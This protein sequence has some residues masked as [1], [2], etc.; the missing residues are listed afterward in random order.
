[1]DSSIAPEVEQIPELSNATATSAALVNLDETTAVDDSV[2]ALLGSCDARFG[3]YGVSP[4]GS[5]NIC[6]DASFLC[7]NILG[8]ANLRSKRLNF[9][10]TEGTLSAYPT[11]YR[12]AILLV[13]HGES[14]CAVEPQSGKFLQE[15]FENGS[16]KYLCIGKDD[17]SYSTLDHLKNRLCARVGYRKPQKIE[18]L[19]EQINPAS[20][21][22]DAEEVARRYLTR[23]QGNRTKCKASCQQVGS[24]KKIFG[25]FRQLCANFCDTTSPITDQWC[26]NSNYK[27]NLEPSDFQPKNLVPSQIFLTSNH[28]DAI[29]TSSQE[30]YLPAIDV[31]LTAVAKGKSQFWQWYAGP[32]SGKSLNPCSFALRGNQTAAPMFAPAVNVTF[33]VQGSG[34]IKYGTERVSSSYSIDLPAM[35]RPLT[36]VA[37][38]ASGHS[39]IGW[40]DHALPCGLSTGCNVTMGNVSAI[41]ITARFRQIPQYRPGPSPRP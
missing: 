39:F 15:H 19:N 30:L 34:A 29:Y 16:A 40:A 1:M 14:L 3:D 18:V 41:N 9:S 25:A 35:N 27:L 12:H 37:E 6:Q 7:K 26:H 28:V 32:C 5:L 21:L 20:T 17:R 24:S 22:S 11:T 8:A 36:F 4:D 33:A 23:A 13:Q 10:C 31:K 38:A 2:L